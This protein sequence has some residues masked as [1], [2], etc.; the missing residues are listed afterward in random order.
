MREEIIAKIEDKKII[1]II[2]GLDTDSA[3]KTA[4]AL[5]KGGIELI[6]VT[7][8]KSSTD[9]Y[10]ETAAS[11]AGIKKRCKNVIVGAGT[12]LTTAQVDVAMN[13]GAE[14][15][16]SPDADEKIIRYTVEKGLVSIPGA[17]TATEIKKA[18]DAGADF[19][20][21]FPCLDNAAAY[22]KAIKAP[23]SHIKLF[24]VGGV[25]ADNAGEFVKAGATGVGV[26]SALVNK[27]Y[28]KNGE[29]EK[30]SALAEKFVK[31]L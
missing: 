7:F 9:G 14:F 5:E 18:H 4:V 10:Q 23:L 25:N 20:K 12:V 15:I 17:F 1:A 22:I 21:L 24:A 26:G 2:R 30:I 13:A 28:V 6:E 8:D 31:S 27:R 19:V 16:I 3:V 29:F 11:I